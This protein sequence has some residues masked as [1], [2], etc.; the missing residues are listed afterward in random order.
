MLTLEDDKSVR[1]YPT[2]YSILISDTKFQIFGWKFLA[3]LT[4][5]PIDSTHI[6][7]P[8]E[9]SAHEFFIEDLVAFLGDD[10]CLTYS[11]EIGESNVYLSGSIIF[12]G[13]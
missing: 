4:D 5:S 6:S 10:G 3:P 9:S 8:E 12:I 2:L 7:G 13:C 11:R 1:I